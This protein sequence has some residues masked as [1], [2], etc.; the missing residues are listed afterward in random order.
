M[1]FFFDTYAAMLS[2]RGG[3]DFPRDVVGLPGIRPKLRSFHWSAEIVIMRSVSH[4]SAQLGRLASSPIMKTKTTKVPH[5]SLSHRHVPKEGTH[6]KVL[7]FS[8]HY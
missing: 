2:A 5:N 4:G 6:K 7:N 8:L 1:L 3:T